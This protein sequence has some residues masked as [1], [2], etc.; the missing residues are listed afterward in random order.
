MP[1]NRSPIR[2]L[3]LVAVLLC[4]PRSNDNHLRHPLARLPLSSPP[5]PPNMQRGDLFHSISKHGTLLRKQPA[6]NKALVCASF[7][8][9]QRRSRSK[10]HRHT[11]SERERERARE[12]QSVCVFDRVLYAYYTYT[13]FLIGWKPPSATKPR[14]NL[15]RPLLTGLIRRQISQKLGLRFY[16]L[17]RQMMYMYGPDVV[18]RTPVRRRKVRSEERTGGGKHVSTSGSLVVSCSAHSGVYLP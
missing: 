18:T 13:V 5:P 8:L 11:E 10:E 14:A 16:T 4:L 7:F 17:K 2:V 12:V 3:T 15:Q 9:K 6:C 1:T